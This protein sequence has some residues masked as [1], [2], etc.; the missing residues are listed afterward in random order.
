MRV[1]WKS[2]CA[3]VRDARLVC[4]M[5]P[6]RCWCGSE[7]GCHSQAIGQPRQEWHGNGNMIASLEG[8]AWWITVMLYCNKLSG[9]L[10]HALVVSTFLARGSQSARRRLLARY[11]QYN[12]LPTFLNL[13]AHVAHPRPPCPSQPH[14]DTRTHIRLIP[15][16]PITRIPSHPQHLPWKRRP[17]TATSEHHSGLIPPSHLAVSPHT[18]AMLANASNT[19]QPAA[20]TTLKQEEALPANKPYNTRRVSLS[21]SS[22]GIHVPGTN[23][24]RA[25]KTQRQASSS[26][27]TP[28]VKRA[29]HQHTPSAP[30][31]SASPSPP[32][33]G[34]ARSSTNTSI[35]RPVVEQTPPPS[36][37]NA[38]RSK[39]LDLEGIN[40][41]VVVAVLE[42]LQSTGNRPHLIKELS[43]ILMNTTATV[44]R[45]V[46]VHPCPLLLHSADSPL[47]A[48]SSNP[49]AIISSRLTN[50]LRRPWTALAPCPL[51]KE[52]VMT[53]PRRVYYFLT[54]QPRQE[55]PE[56]SDSPATIKRTA[57][58]LSIGPDEDEEEEMMVDMMDLSREARSL[59]PEVDL[60]SHELEFS[61][62]QSAPDMSF[63]RARQTA[64]DASRA[65]DLEI[66]HNSRAVSPPLSNE[67]REFTMTAS[68]LQLRKQ[69]EQEE[70]ELAQL[71]A[72]QS[73]AM[74]LDG[75]ISFSTSPEDSPA[76]FVQTLPQEPEEESEERAAQRNRE[77]ADVLF[78]HGHRLLHVPAFSSP[79]LRPQHLHLSTTPRKAFATTDVTVAEMD[80]LAAWPELQSPEEVEL[81]ELDDMLG[82]F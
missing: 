10:R 69:S 24:A 25:N 16:L 32:P 21:L 70:M 62:P 15:S 65:T 38:Q 48:S 19:P 54:T 13:H 1:A 75:S 28:P 58:P 14:R 81:D 6:S 7:G 35:H 4:A 82:G 76:V 51:T 61:H 33:K 9:T 26:L 49:N 79:V 27:D 77:A 37:G 45:Q 2:V 43:N 57:T 34:R 42:Q 68:F 56:F 67:E 64:E 78:G 18:T 17:D 73:D 74:S 40:D 63:D 60:S 47:L 39:L 59:S 66:A 71:Q 8:C 53:H 46:V 36:P 41:D 5:H 11:Q 55:I 50:Y 44:R 3:M 80:A 31:A 72:Q 20:V 23:S 12:I 30:S 29:K 22:L 52:Q